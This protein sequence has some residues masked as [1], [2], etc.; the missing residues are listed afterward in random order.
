[1]QYRLD[2]TLQNCQQTI[3]YEFVFV[4]VL[5]IGLTCVNHVVLELLMSANNIKLL[6]ANCYADKETAEDSQFL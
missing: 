6:H 3:V 5:N 1:M 2:E 4:F